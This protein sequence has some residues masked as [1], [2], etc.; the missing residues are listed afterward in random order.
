[1]R[2][3][4]KALLIGVVL[5]AVAGPAT[6]QWTHDT[7]APVLV[8]FRGETVSS[9]QTCR[10]DASG[11]LEIT[12]DQMRLRAK[13]MVVHQAG[14]PGSCGEVIR[15]EADR[16]VLYVTPNERV[17]AD[18]ADYDFVNDTLTFTG[19]VVVVRGQDVAAT[20]RLVI[21]VKTNA[22]RMSGG[23]KAVIYQERAGQ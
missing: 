11:D 20:E 5:A 22:T 18:H 13:T 19:G 8:D 10:S 6:A 9:A 3:R 1:M 17:R 14:R 16:D 21:N 2:G 4:L 7:R 23:V 15:A 12:Q